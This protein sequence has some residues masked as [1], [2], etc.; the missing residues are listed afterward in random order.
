MDSSPITLPLGTLI[1][2]A[3]G[4]RPV[5]RLQAG[6]AVLGFDASSFSRVPLVLRQIQVVESVLCQRVAVGGRVAL[7]SPDTLCPVFTVEGDWSSRPITTLA[8]G[9]LLP[10]DRLIPQP[11]DPIPLPALDPSLTA[12]LDENRL[13][14]LDALYDRD[15]YFHEMDKRSLRLALY[16]LSGYLVGAMTVVD[17]RLYLPTDNADL[18][19]HYREAF[20]TTFGA[21][22]LTDPHLPARL[23]RWLGDGLAPYAERTLPY[24]TWE[25][26][27]PALH[28]FLR[29]LF[30]A[31]GQV[32]E[33]E[34]TLTHPHLP[35]VVGLQ[36]LLGRL[37]LDSIVEL[38]PD[39]YHLVIRNVRRFAEW[40]NSNVATAAGIL[41][42]VYQ[43]EPRYP[44]ES[45]ALLPLN[46]VRPVLSRLRAE[47]TFRRTTADSPDEYEAANVATLR[48]LAGAFHDPDLR[49]LVNQQLYL[50]PLTA[51]D[52]LVAPLCFSLTLDPPATLIA[53]GVILGGE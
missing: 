29:G 52:T 4:P 12:R 53:N 23:Q 22:A 19:H 10:I 35:F 44:L 16:E 48:L 7:C 47:H 11:A 13:T 49:A 33:G 41:R 26:P 39:G 9:D 37:H 34:I 45:T 38:A 5:E 40:I 31:L 51:T 1:W 14:L 42:H 8:L 18:V 20:F 46:R 36:T 32:S 25:L 43:R 28:A 27:T 15:K 30:D 17:H 50:E 3:D 6:E 21:D 2:T 24:W